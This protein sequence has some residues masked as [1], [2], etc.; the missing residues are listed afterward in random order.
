MGSVTV[1]PRAS[2]E[3]VLAAVAA[4]EGAGP[5]TIGQIAQQVAGDLGID[6]T[7]VVGMYDLRSA[8]S[9]QGLQTEVRLLVE[10]GSLVRRTEAGWARVAQGLLFAHKLPSSTTWAYCTPAGAQAVQ[11]LAQGND[12]VMRRTL[13]EQYAVRRLAML[14]PVQY[15]ELM[16]EWRRAHPLPAG[17]GKS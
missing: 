9:W 4:L 7:R 6:M 1:L 12:G 13:A 10:S 14:Y 17:E 5:V 2:R 8:I 3:Q 16:E 11:E 15:E